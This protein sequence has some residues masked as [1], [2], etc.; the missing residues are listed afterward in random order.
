MAIMTTSG[1]AP[2]LS[3]PATHIFE[4]QL[5]VEPSTNKNR[6]LP[7]EQLH[8]T[9]EIQKTVSEIRSNKYKRVA[10]QFPDGMLRDA[11]RI[12]DALRHGLKATIPARN[13]TA[14]ASKPPELADNTDDSTVSSGHAS[15]VKLYILGDT[16]YGACCVD[17]IAAEHV[18]ADAVVHYGRACL[19]PTARLPVIYVF[20][21]QALPDQTLLAL[22]FESLFKDKDQKIILMADVTHQGHLQ[23]VLVDL[24][25]RSYK[26]LF[27]T[28][29]VNNPS[30]LLPNRTIPAEAATTPSKLKEWQLFHVS[31]P[32]ES[33]LLTLSSRVGSIYIYPTATEIASGAIKATTSRAL[34]R[35][36]ALLTSVSTTAIFGILINTLSVKNYMRVEEHVKSRILES[37]KKSYTFVVGKVNAAKLANFGEI[38][39]WIVIGCWESSLIDSKDFYKPV[40]TPFELDLALKNDRERIWTGEW[41]GDFQ[42][43]LDESKNDSPHPNDQATINGNHSGDHVGDAKDQDYD[44][45]PESAPPEFDLRTGRYVSSSRPMQS[46]EAFKNGDSSIEGVKSQ[47]SKSLVKKAKGDL[48]IIGGQ[49]SPGAE[50]LQTRRT[51]KGLGSDFEIAYEEG[52]APMEEGSRGIARGYTHG[53]DGVRG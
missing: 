26:N 14:S 8:V 29:V 28:D 53:E 46:S 20:T 47:S 39:A 24:Q 18:N 7:D 38:G 19:S 45:E 9:Y 27:R 3:T 4:N 41:S 1:G 30:S 15:E 23:D 33:L 6:T 12:F 32:P 35:R 36:Y 2:A 10:L 11:P 5:N 25:S 40:I 22:N 43:L 21:V 13:R 52:G 16:S 34:K 50:F 31:D 51:W 42:K 37:G 44:S 48:A 17:E 49:P